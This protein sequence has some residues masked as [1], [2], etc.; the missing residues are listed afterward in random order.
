MRLDPSITTLAVALGIGLLIGAERERRKGESPERGAAG[1]RTFAAASLAGAAGLLAAG[2][3][4]LSVTVAASAWLAGLGYWRNRNDDPGLTTEI[5][6]VLTVLLGALCVRA[7]GLAAG[8]AVVVAVLLATRAPLHRF[9]RLGFSA[10]E[11]RDAL[12]LAS[13]ALV[14]LP[15]LPARAAGPFNAFNPHVVGLVIVLVLAIGAAGHVAVRLVGERFGLPIAGL[16]SGFVSSVATIGAM[17]ARARKS[18]S[19]LA[20]AASAAILSTLAT[21]LQLSVVIGATN[22]ATLRV[23]W[24]LLAAGGTVAIVYGGALTL[25]AARTESEPAAPEA[26][27]FSILGAVV[28]AATV[29]SV[30]FV[31][32]ALRAWLGEPGVLAAAALAGFA[33]AHAAAIS[34]AAL[35]GDGKLAAHDAVAPILAGFLTNTV[36]KV[37]FAISVGGRPFAIRVTPGLVLVA[38]AAALAAFAPIA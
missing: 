19:A 22:F 8:T 30:L 35:V 24:P 34:V 31:S 20:S 9:V 17:G 33:D 16:I 29:A 15:L 25:A 12:I 14:I 4:G 3:V 10:R 11:A 5:A 37:V 26:R 6:L 32:A 7:P 13:A 18:P 21:V 27:A 2:G 23:V 28:F 38:T 1:I 36:S